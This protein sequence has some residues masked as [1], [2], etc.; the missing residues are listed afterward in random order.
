MTKLILVR[1]GESLGNYVDKFLGHT[2][3]DLSPMGYKQAEFVKE[4]F[5]NVHIDKI[6][7]SDLL[8]AYNTII[9][10]AEEKKIPVIKSEKLREIYAGEWEN[11]TFDEICAEFDQEYRLWRENIGLARCTG[12]ECV[13]DLQKRIC[14]ELKKIC[15]ENPDKTICIATHATPIRVFAAMCLGYPLDKI[16]DIKWA[17]NASVNIFNYSEGKFEMLEYGNVSH[18]GDCVTQIPKNV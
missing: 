18:L 14:D 4:Y 5:R 9:S 16:K 11:L 8:R 13:E 15:D 7:S 17:K 1:H 3:L 10:T 2:D 6:Y 12:G